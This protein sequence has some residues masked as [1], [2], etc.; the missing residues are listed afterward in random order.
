[1]VDLHQG[2]PGL[3]DGHPWKNYSR[4]QMAWRAFCGV[5]F[6]GM[7]GALL[8]GLLP[9]G[10]GSPSVAGALFGLGIPILA[11]VLAAA[12][13]VWLRRYFPF[14]QALLFGGLTLVLVL[15]IASLLSLWEWI[16]RGPCAADTLCSGPFDGALYAL[17]LLGFPGFLSACIGYGV[18]IWA[19]TS[20]G[21]KVFWPFFS[22]IALAFIATA[23][24]SAF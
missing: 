17:F 8:S 2:E 24:L 14:S 11:A 12:F 10:V 13:G 15:L 20:R 5:S 4:W 6:A 9:G 3:P 18:A 19:A 7:A 1:M 21:S 23:V 22:V 16:V